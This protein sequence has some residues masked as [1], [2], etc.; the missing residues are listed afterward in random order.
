MLKAMLGTDKNPGQFLI[1]LA[2]GV[3]MLPHGAQKVLGWFGGPGYA[4]TLAQ[5][6]AL[7]FPRWAVLLLMLTE[8]GGGF[9][10]LIG[11]LTRLWALAIGGAMVLCLWLN[12]VQHGFFMNWSGQQA[13]EGIEFHILLL[14]I[15]LALALGG[16]GALSLDRRL[17]ASRGRASSLSF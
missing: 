5:F 13:G 2:L 4:T 16:G 12:H 11:L 7:G 10:L 8:L 6:V 15:S 1:R 3:V 17:A 9:F 14:A